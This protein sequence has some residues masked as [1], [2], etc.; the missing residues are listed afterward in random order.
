VI[1][2]TPAILVGLLKVAPLDELFFAMTETP[3]R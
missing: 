1:A 2:E 3:L